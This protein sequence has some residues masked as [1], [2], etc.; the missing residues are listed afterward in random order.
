MVGKV[1]VI[2]ECT[3][4]KKKKT[5][6]E[7]QQSIA[8]TIEK[9]TYGCPDCGGKSIKVNLSQYDRIAD[10]PYH[11]RVKVLADSPADTYRVQRQNIL[12]SM[13]PGRDKLGSTGV[14]VVRLMKRFNDL[15]H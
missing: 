15:A 12:G 9:K 11:G 2:L 5:L 6:K 3:E 1:N 14:V 7:A 8:N 4:C 13:S 10:N